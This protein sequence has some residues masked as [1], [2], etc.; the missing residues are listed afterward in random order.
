MFFFFHYFNCQRDDENWVI[1]SHYHYCFLIVA[2]AL[3]EMQP[4]CKD[5]FIQVSQ[6]LKRS[7]FDQNDVFKNPPFSI[8]CRSN[9]GRLKPT[10]LCAADALSYTDD[11]HPWL[12][13]RNCRLICGTNFL[14][15][16]TKIIHT[17]RP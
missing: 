14:I 1:H 11:V 17:A 16:E 4:K 8:E 10:V 13:P 9:V 7:K 3:L 12:F 5:E 15:L 6:D 2:K